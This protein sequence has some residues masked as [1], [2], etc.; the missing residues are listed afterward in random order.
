M[1]AGIYERRNRRSIFSERSTKHVGWEIALK[2]NGNSQSVPHSGAS[3]GVGLEHEE[4][5]HH[6]S[7]L[8]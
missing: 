8:S 1:N 5:N 4:V 7:S 2:I 6:L 3:D